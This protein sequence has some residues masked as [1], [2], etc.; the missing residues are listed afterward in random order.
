MERDSKGGGG[1]AD[2]GA[3][4][5]KSAPPIARG[6]LYSFELLRW[7]ASPVYL[8]AFAFA[9]QMKALMNDV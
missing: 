2:I 5:K 3:K 8:Q 4:N 9:V 1:T 6:A 7:V